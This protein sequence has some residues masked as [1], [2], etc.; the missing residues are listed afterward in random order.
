MRHGGR[1]LPCFLCVGCKVGEARSG[2]LDGHRIH[3]NAGAARL[4]RCPAV[5]H[6]GGCGIARRPTSRKP[7]L[8]L[9]GALDSALAG[10]GSPD[11][12]PPEALRDRSAISGESPGPAGDTLETD[13]GIG[14]A[15]GSAGRFSLVV[16]LMHGAFYFRL[17][18]GETGDDL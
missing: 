17:Q 5:F 3:A 15:G 7:G 12:C 9:V 14:L 13:S 18:V 16:V 4:R 8:R 11:G 2:Q 6:A 1:A 10:C